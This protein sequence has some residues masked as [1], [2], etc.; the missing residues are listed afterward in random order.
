MPLSVSTA[1]EPVGHRCNL[2]QSKVN[3]SVIDAIAE[4]VL[5]SPAMRGRRDAG[6]D[7]AIL[8]LQ[9]AEATH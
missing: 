3:L 4:R 6:P 1:C 8:V 7:L 9:V 5:L 2:S